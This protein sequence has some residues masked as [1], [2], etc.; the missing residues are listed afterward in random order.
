LA[1]PPAICLAPQYL[2]EERL[3]AEGFTDVQYV[4]MEPGD[5]T[6]ALAAG[7]VDMSMFT[8]ANLIMEVDAGQ[9]IV[10][11]AGV[12]VGCFELFAG[13][14][15]RSLTD[16]KGKRVAVSFLRSGRHAVLAALLAHVGLDAT[17][18]VTWITDP[19][20]EAIRRFAAGEIDA[21]MAFPPEPQEL[22]ARG[23]GRVLVNMHLDR[24]WNQYFCCLVAG[25][26]AFVR[27]HPVA[28]GRAVRAILGAADACA[29]EPEL[30][31]HALVDGGYPAR[32]DQAF[33]ML[34]DVPYGT[35]RDDDPEDTVRF[36][37]LRLQEAGMTRSSPQKVIARGTDWRFLEALKREAPAQLPPTAMATSPQAAAF[38]CRLNQATAV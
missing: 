20:P 26:Q 8:A 28:T 12:H 37:A 11:L 24:P 10:M 16:L 7:D 1:R 17:R 36:F 29:R 13:A 27:K 4:G 38:L 2:A 35:W 23:I 5:V 3:H 15:I 18:D 25:N 34:H 9:P 30:A 32:Y 31:A 33:Q 6:R 19:V 14:G 22:R 21:F